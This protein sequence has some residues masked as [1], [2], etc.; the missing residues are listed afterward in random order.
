MEEIENVPA[1]PKR[2]KKL[3]YPYSSEDSHNQDEEEN[4]NYEVED[5][6]GLIEENSP[7]SMIEVIQNA[8]KDLVNDL[9]IDRKDESE[10]SNAADRLNSKDKLDDFI[11]MIQSR[12]QEV[13]LLK[14]KRQKE[15][16][17]KAESI[18]SEN[19]STDISN[20]DG[21]KEETLENNDNALIPL[22]DYSVQ[23]QIEVP[24]RSKRL[25]G[26]CT[27]KFRIDMHLSSIIY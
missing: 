15:L 24:S 16:E 4:K 9:S 3:I 23:N 18:H 7:K 10:D 27:G 22:N 5:R 6:S 1:V 14:E 19:L 26:W 2:K 8:K 21:P 17:N 25:N 13:K 11:M 12:L 20:S